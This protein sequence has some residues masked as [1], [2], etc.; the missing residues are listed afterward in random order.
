VNDLQLQFLTDWAEAKREKMLDGAHYFPHLEKG[1]IV[2]QFQS[3]EGVGLEEEICKLIQ[4]AKRE[5]TIGTP[6]FIPGKKAFQSVKHALRRGVHIT[7]ILPNMSDHF[8][9]KEASYRYLRKLCPLGASIYHYHEGFYHAKVFIVDEKLCSIGTVNMDKRSFYF[10][11]EMSCFFY[12]HE[13]VKKMIQM[14]K[15]DLL[16]STKLNIEML[17]GRGSALWV[18]EWLAFLVSPFL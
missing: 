7:I 10:N 14:V 17:D 12:D 6:Y 16:K 13:M 2:H 18:K 9:I 8:L 15:R 11:H 4:E 5:V 1:P 3:F